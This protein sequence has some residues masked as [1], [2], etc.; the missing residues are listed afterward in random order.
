MTYALD[1]HE[2]KRECDREVRERDGAAVIH[3]RMRRG[4][5]LLCDAM[6]IRTHLDGPGAWPIGAPPS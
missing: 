3:L 6:L 1:V 5:E 4:E 2:L